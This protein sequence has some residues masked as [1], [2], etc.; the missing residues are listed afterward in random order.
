MP[1]SPRAAGL[2]PDILERD[3]KL[4]VAPRVAAH[5]VRDSVNGLQGFAEPRVRRPVTCR[6]ARPIAPVLVQCAMH[7]RGLLAMLA[8]VACGGMLSSAPLCRPCPT[9]CIVH[10]SDH[11]NAKP[12]S[13]RASRSASRRLDKSAFPGDHQPVTGVLC[14]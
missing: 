4:G 11:P 14:D 3:A 1:G 2:L 5:Y 12:D 13:P 10:V 8:G 6:S 9:L 7:D